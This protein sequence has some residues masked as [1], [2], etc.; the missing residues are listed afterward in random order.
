MTEVGAAPNFA[1]RPHSCSLPEHFER[2]VTV[3][4]FAAGRPVK[5]YRHDDGDYTFERKDGSGPQDF[6]FATGP[7]A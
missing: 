4:K 1:I 6:I 2:K 3:K 7:K 5:V